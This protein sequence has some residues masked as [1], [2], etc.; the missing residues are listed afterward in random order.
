MSSVFKQYSSPTDVA[1]ILQAFHACEATNWRDKIF[2]LMGF[3]VV[4]TALAEV[5]IDYTFSTEALYTQV[6]KIILNQSEKLDFLSYHWHW[7]V[8]ESTAHLKQ[9]CRLSHL[10]C[11]D[12]MSLPTSKGF[13]SVLWESSMPVMAYHA[14]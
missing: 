11:L 12:G 13:Y 2:A 5:T 1:R 3:E 4:Q 10:G 8:A 9:H 6:A 14:R 7:K